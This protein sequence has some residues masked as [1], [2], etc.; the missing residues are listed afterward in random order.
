MIP[1]LPSAFVVTVTAAY[2]L[3]FGSFANV[4]IFRLPRERSIVFPPSACP[5]C[6]R[7]IRWF[8]NVPVFAWLLLRGRCR[9]CHEP[10]S[11]RYPL[12]ELLVG[13]L[14]GLAAARHPGAP[15]AIAAEAILGFCLVV[16]IFTDLDLQLLPALVTDG[17]LVLALALSFFRPE[18]PPLRALLGAA[19]G[20]GILFVISWVFQKVRGHEG[21]GSGDPRMLAMIGAFLGAPA[22]L[23]TLALASLVGAIV[24]IG[25]AAA[26]RPFGT[27]RLP[28][29]VFL[30][31]AALAVAAEGDWLL[32]ALG[33]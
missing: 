3:L 26:G 22:A 14:F 1:P 9:D 27:T 29:G 16:L 7:R 18:L 4:C 17:G 30:A 5:G 15:A 24:G 21:M 13:L 12:V 23:L 8:D 28:F 33:F 20:G 19:V 6:G 11:P 10:I 2:G 25:L 31:L 32:A